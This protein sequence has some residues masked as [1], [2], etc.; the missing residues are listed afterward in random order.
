MHAA[1]NY[2]YIVFAVLYIIYSIIKAGRKA[3]QQKPSEKGTEPS[4]TV[5]PPTSAP[6]PQPGSELGD[7][8]KKMLEEIL[9]KKPEIK[10]PEKPIS[11]PQPVPIKIQPKKN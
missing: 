6:L 5:K 11:K 10:I 2:I 4:S 1:T 8:M 9:G 7:D 3:V